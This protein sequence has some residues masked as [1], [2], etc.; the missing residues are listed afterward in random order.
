MQ[1]VFDPDKAPQKQGKNAFVI[2]NILPYLNSALILVV[3]III[4]FSLRD[5]KEPVLQ[6]P[7]SDVPLTVAVQSL[8]DR[9]EV[10]DKSLEAVRE[11]IQNLARDQFEAQ[12]K[13]NDA[14]SALK[15]ADQRNVITPQMG[16]K[17]IAS[18]KP[19]NLTKEQKSAFDDLIN[20]DNDSGYNVSRFLDSL[21]DPAEKNA[22]LKI[23]QS[24]GDNWFNSALKALKAGNREDADKLLSTA[25]YFYGIIKEKSGSEL[26]ASHVDAKLS[27]YQL[28]TEKQDM[29]RQMNQQMAQQK[30]ELEQ[31][32]QE[33]AQAAQEKNEQLKAQLEAATTHKETAT[34]AARR[35]EENRMRNSGIKPY[36]GTHPKKYQ[37][38]WDPDPRVREQRGIIQPNE[39]DD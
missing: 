14:E 25:N 13:S 35:L 26:T 38:D 39:R 10:V 22:Y 30:E 4:V 20:G 12:A 29:Q 34:E 1:N 19:V 5:K 24:K 16:E 21:D 11:E 18:T 6:T 37:T 27:Q 36:K 7:T 23:L 17:L 33:N 8:N 31:K 15:E 3:L 32:M 2:K 28:E 9:M